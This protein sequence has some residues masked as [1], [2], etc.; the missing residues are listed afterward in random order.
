[1]KRDEGITREEEKGMT[2]TFWWWLFLQQKVWFASGFVKKEKEQKILLSVVM[3]FNKL[4]IIVMVC[5]YS[6]PSHT[7]Q[8]ERAHF[9]AA[10]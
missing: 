2:R 9:C 5:T 7:F 1:M 6:F 8:R 10:S 3:K 4:Q